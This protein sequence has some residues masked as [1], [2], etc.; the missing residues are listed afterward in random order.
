MSDDLKCTTN[1]HLTPFTLTSKAYL[2]ISMVLEDLFLLL[3]FF[4]RPPI[5]LPIHN[6]FYPSKWWAVGSLHKAMLSNLSMFLP[7]SY[8][9]DFSW[10]CAN[11]NSVTS[12]LLLYF[13]PTPGNVNW[14]NLLSSLWVNQLVALK[15]K[16][17]YW[18]C[19]SYCQKIWHANGVSA[20]SVLSRWI[21]VSC[22]ART[23]GATAKDTTLSF[24][25][26]TRH[27]NVQSGISCF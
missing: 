5:W 16:H 4:T 24:Q 23:S 21:L 19:I 14:T 18:R 22:K 25:T 15:F 8:T 11:T 17:P 27:R 1:T 13:G 20:T 6:G 7:Q 26:N 2:T 3:H 9:S 10:Y 12:S